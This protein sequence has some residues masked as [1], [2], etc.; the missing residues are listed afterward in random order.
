MK[1]LA[2]KLNVEI[3]YKDAHH[4]QFI[5]Q[6]LVNYYPHSK[7]KTAYIA[8]TKKGIHGV[9]FNRT[10]KMA[11]RPP[12]IKKNHDRRK[13]H[14]GLKKKLLE[15]N[16]ICHWCPTELTHETATIEHI[17]PLGRGGLDNPNN[18]T[19]ACKP[20]NETRGNNMPEMEKE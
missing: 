7:G 6:L 13:P 20:C 9:N 14:W 18:I 4:I 2:E 17:I 12:S 10:I 19:L 15:K 3:I 11:N 16:N 5:G 8:G 1:E